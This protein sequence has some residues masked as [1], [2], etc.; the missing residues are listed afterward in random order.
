MHECTNKESDENDF[1]LPDHLV[2]HSM[3]A[4]DAQMK[5]NP[6]RPSSETTKAI[7]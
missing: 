7:L 1:W 3:M 2:R 5:H 6:W 4:V